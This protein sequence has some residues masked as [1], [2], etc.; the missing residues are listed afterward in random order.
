[1]AKWGKDE[2]TREMISTAD[3][4]HPEKIE[5]V[6]DGED[7][8]M[9]DE[10]AVYFSFQMARGKERKAWHTVSLNGNDVLHNDEWKLTPIVPIYFIECGSGFRPG[11]GRPGGRNIAPYSYHL[12]QI[13]QT[14]Y[15]QLKGSKTIV[16]FEKGSDPQLSD[17]NFA[18]V[19]VPQGRSGTVKVHPMKTV[20]AEALAERQSVVDDAL[21]EVGLNEGTSE[22]SVPGQLSSG[23]AITKYQNEI[24]ISLSE[25]SHKINMARVRSARIKCYYMAE[26]YKDKEILYQAANSADLEAIS[27]PS[28]NIKENTWTVIVQTA[29]ALPDSVAGK[30]ETMDAFYKLDVL[31]AI[32]MAEKFVG[33]RRRDQVGKAFEGDAVAVVDEALYGFGEGNDFGHRCCSHWLDSATGQGGE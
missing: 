19:E 15:E 14:V 22:G 23:V 28:L 31:D 9:E 17:A 11:S 6:D 25:H 8:E 26:L 30:L 29:G 12:N 16:E 3:C 10:I 24:A 32:D 18:K 21:A 4:E 1:M 33:R 5:G 13:T 20:S 2:L 7:D 27:W